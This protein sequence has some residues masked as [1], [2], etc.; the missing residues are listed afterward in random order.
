[1][2][3]DIEVLRETL[4]FYALPSNWMIR[5][6]MPT[7]A[8]PRAITDAGALARLALMQTENTYVGECVGEVRALIEQELPLLGAYYP[9]EVEEVRE[10]L[11]T[12]NVR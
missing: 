1:M 5:G 11:K 10:H 6:E 3:T 4:D 9:D 12:W 8:S 2:R 7:P